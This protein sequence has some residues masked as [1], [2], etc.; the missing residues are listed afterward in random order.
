MS[1]L[2]NLKLQKHVV[3]MFAYYCKFIKNFLDK[4]FPLNYNETFLLQPEIPNVRED[5][6]DVMLAT[7]NYNESFEVQTDTRNFYTASSL[8]Q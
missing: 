3:K 5:L 8:N 7:V 1:R 6:K 2:S 4:I